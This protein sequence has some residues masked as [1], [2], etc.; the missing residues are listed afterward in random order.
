MRVG[1]KVAPG[2]RISVSNRG[3]RLGVGPRVARVHVGA[4]PTRLSSG[5]GPVSASMALGGNRG[6]TGSNRAGTPR[7]ARPPSEAQLQKEA[8]ARDLRGQIEEIRDLHRQEFPTIRKPIVEPFDVDPE[9]VHWYHV[10]RCRRGEKASGRS[11]AE[12]AVM[13]RDYASSELRMFEMLHANQVLLLQPDL[14]DWWHS[15]QAGDVEVITDALTGA[16]A[17]N[18]ASAVVAGVEDGVARSRS[19]WLSR[20]PPRSPPDG[21]RPRKPELRPYARSP[22]PSQLSCI[23][24]SC[25]DTWW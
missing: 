19:S 10:E 6:R 16:F 5:Y 13:A 1:I 24:T 20:T 3:V 18:V 17:D 4:G 12:S 9:W 21:R 22:Q 2:M 8:E 7:S 23:V 14:D 15:L 11:P 25:S